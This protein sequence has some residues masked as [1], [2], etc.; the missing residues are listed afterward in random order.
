MSSKLLSYDDVLTAT[1]GQKKY[2]LLGNG[3]SMSYNVERFSFTSL[4]KSAVDSGLISKSSPIYAVFSEFDTKD[5]EEVIKLLETSV[6]VLKTYSSI[7]ESDEKAI[8]EDSKSLKKYLVDV[9]TNNHPEK[10]T[11]ISDS[12]YLSSANFIKEYEKIYTLNYDLLLYWTSMKLDSFL[13]DGSIKKSTLK[14]SDGFNDLY[15]QS[16]DYVVF[17]NGGKSFNINFLHGG[18]H[19]FD[20]KSEIIKNTY[21]PS[22]CI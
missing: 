4:L 1:K 19:I 16:T 15:Q 6:K 9:I 22:F 17:E 3:F 7:S 14:I 5:F 2:L 11:E 18:L 13:H 21:L 12:E 10:I 8:L 20:N